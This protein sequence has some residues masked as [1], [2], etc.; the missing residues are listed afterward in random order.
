MLTRI[1]GRAQIDAALQTIAAELELNAKIVKP[2][3]PHGDGYRPADVA[4]GIQTQQWDTS[5]AEIASLRRWH[6]DIW[7]DLQDVYSDLRLTKARGQYP[8][9][10]DH[11]NNLA[12]RLRSVRV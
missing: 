5:G 9:T 2:C 7:T 8:P 1:R 4:D 11:L 6:A 12:T 10:S 3:E